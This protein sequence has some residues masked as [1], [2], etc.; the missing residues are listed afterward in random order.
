MESG[1]GPLPFYNSELVLKNEFGKISFDGG[2]GGEG[3]KSYIGVF[4]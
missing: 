3:K 1:L 4:K 2:G